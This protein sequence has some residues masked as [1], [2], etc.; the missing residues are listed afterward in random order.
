MFSN[1]VSPGFMKQADNSA[2][3]RFQ[4]CFGRINMLTPAEGCPE[5]QSFRHLSN[6]AFSETVTSELL[7]L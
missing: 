4:Q 3:G 1:L 2:D 7:K 6:H 5:V